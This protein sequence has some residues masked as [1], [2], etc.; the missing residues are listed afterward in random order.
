[1][2][3]NIGLLDG[4]HQE[5]NAYSTS[6]VDPTQGL[7]GRPHGGLTV[8][9][10]KRFS[11]FVDI[12]LFDDSRI[13]GIDVSIAGNILHVLNVYL[14]YYS[15]QNYDLYLEYIGKI[16]S[17]F[18]SREHSELIIFGDFNADVGREY[19]N[20][21]DSVCDQFGLIFADVNFLPGTTYTHVNNATLTTSWL[22]HILCSQTVFGAI[23]NISVDENYHGSDHLPL[24]AT[25]VLS[26]LP[27]YSANNS[28]DDTVDIKWNFD[29]DHK[30]YYFYE[31]LMYYISGIE[32]ISCSSSG[33]ICTDEEHVSKID[34]AYNS[35]VESTL[36]AGEEIFGRRR[37]GNNRNIPGWNDHVKDL[38]DWSRTAF[39]HWREPG[40][41]R[42]GLT[43]WFVGQGKI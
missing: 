34:A 25:L 32:T 27:T 28:A 12:K 2:H 16:C 41:P 9:W 24:C 39:L 29:D 15:V 1:M 36:A 4:V 31:K 10:R 17:I 23:S 30:C 8:L 43:V 5:F 11:A 7:V 38:Y 37:C 18:E 20:E 21:W 42:H 40:S 3:H 6:A 14:P 35:V 19:F 33:R 26:E 13:L 22:D